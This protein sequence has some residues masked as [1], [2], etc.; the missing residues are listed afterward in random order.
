ME[1]LTY[2]DLLDED[3][4]LMDDLFK[5]KEEKIAE[6]K[7]MRDLIA[8]LKKTELRCTREIMNLSQEAIGEKFELGSTAAK[9]LKKLDRVKAEKRI[10]EKKKIGA[11]SFSANKL[12]FNIPVFGEPSHGTF[13]V[14]I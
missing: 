7:I 3:K 6:R 14:T 9:P 11:H 5:Y 2:T 4:V 10:A 8:Q 1:S 13:M 12:N